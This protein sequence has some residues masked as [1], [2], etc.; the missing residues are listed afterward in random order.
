ML[1]ALLSPW[2]LGLLGLM[3][4]SF[5]NVVI[6]RMPR[7]FERQWWADVAGQLA[8]RESFRRVFEREAPAG[9]DQ[10]ANSLDKAIGSLKALNL[11]Y[12]ASRCVSC[13]HVIRWY[14]NIPVLSWLWLKGRCSACGTGI[15]W[16]Y[17]A[18]E[19][20]CALLFAAA[21]WRQGPQLDAVLWCGFVAALLALAVIDWDTTVLPDAI[22]QPLLWGGLIAAAAGWLPGLNATSAVFGS[23]VGYLSLWSVY[24]AFKL[25]TGKEGM[26]YGDFK[27]LAVLGGWMSWQAVLPIV[28]LA[29]ASGAVV[30]LFMKA[31]GS[32]REGR[33]VPF[34]PFLVAGGLIV[35]LLGLP[36]VLAFMGWA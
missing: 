11:A 30:G 17:P 28:L 32:L 36:R 33:F 26:G 10:A 14:E 20:V 8:D 15:S 3:V 7:M 9:L 2:T 24:W 6:H 21:A 23:V 27:L 13:G 19:M 35:Y 5:L 16:R 12:P 4:G 31:K 29:S 1:D 25:V 18:V 34:G 22:T